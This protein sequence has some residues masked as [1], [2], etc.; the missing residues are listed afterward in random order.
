[1]VRTSE[2]VAHKPVGAGSSLLSSKGFSAAARKAA[3]FDLHQQ[4]VHGLVNKSPRQHTLQSSVQASNESPAMGRLSLPLHQSSAHP[5]SPEPR[6]KYA[7]EEGDSS[8]RVEVATRVGSDDL[9]P[10]RESGG[11]YVRHERECALP[12]VL[13]PLSLP[14]GRGRA[15]IAL[16]SSQVVCVSSDQDTATGVMQDQG[17]AG[18]IDT[19]RPELAEPAVVFYST[20]WIVDLYHQH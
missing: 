19:R 17:G 18:F 13:L 8:R 3:C 4:N 6:G 7:F 15:E 16:A 11:G 20:C 10:L 9:E 5:R 14:A 12:A 2:P 1:M